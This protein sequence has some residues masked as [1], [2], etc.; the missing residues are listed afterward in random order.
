MVRAN[1]RSNNP[2]WHKSI[3]FSFVNKFKK[4]T[5][6]L[7]NGPKP[8]GDEFSEIP[9]ELK[10]LHIELKIRTGSVS[11][12]KKSDKHKLKMSLGLDYGDRFLAKLVL[13][14]GSILL[15]DSYKKSE[16]AKILREFMWTKSN[17]KREKILIHGTYIKSMMKNI[18]QCLKTTQK[19]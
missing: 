11:N 14:L 13:G 3:L 18:F 15:N 2:V 12:K 17:N 5:L 4:S 6:Y 16:S 19:S 1:W 10:E 9:E 7:G 8:E